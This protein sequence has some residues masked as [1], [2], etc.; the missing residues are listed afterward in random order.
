MMVG[1]VGARRMMTSVGDFELQW[2]ESMLVADGEDHRWWTVE[3]IDATDR[4]VE[5]VTAVTQSSNSG[6][7]GKEQRW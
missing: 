5:T 1:G 2:R 6:C 7:S 4:D 3:R